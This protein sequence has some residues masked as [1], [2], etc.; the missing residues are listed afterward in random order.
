M[1]MMGLWFPEEG[2]E[3]RI[4]RGEEKRGEEKEKEG[5]KG[6]MFWW[7]HLQERGVGGLLMEVGE[8]NNGGEGWEIWTIIRGKMVHE[9]LL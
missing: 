1:D 4:E 5:V 2:R 9:S 3:D 8:D 6:G 7:K